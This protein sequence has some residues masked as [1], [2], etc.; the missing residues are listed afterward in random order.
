MNF[1]VLLSF[2]VVLFLI[3][4]YR[5]SL[6]L[7]KPLLQRNQPGANT[8]KRRNVALKNICCSTRLISLYNKFNADCTL[9]KH[10]S[11]A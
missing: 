3:P 5:N 10:H 8:L 7:Q 11:T 2:I 4:K 9:P 6:Y 1:G